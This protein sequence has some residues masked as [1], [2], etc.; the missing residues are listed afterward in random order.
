M[1]LVHCTCC[2]VPSEVLKRFSQDRALSEQQREHFANTIKIDAEMR[3]LRTQATKL[4][5][6]ASLIAA[7][8]LVGAV[9][10]A[11][12]I[13]VLR[14]Q[15][16]ARRCRARRLPTPALRPTP[17]PSACSPTTTRGGTFYSQVF[18]RNSVDGAGM[19]LISSIHYGVNYNNAFWNGSQMTYGDGD[20]SIFVDFS[21]EQR[22]DRSRVDP[23]RHPAQ[24]AA[25]L[26]QRGGRPQ[27]E[28][29][30]LLRLDVPPMGGQADRRR[31]P[32][33]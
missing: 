4:T 1:T 25:Q 14:L 31:R 20:G 32:T 8:G 26:H 30:R 10:P 22:R 7:P 19:T 27:R 5:R 15:A 6:V 33:G 28:P 3:R 17:P 11:P 29:V 21:K 16:S 9:A 12:A 2:I 18:G 24:P 13:T 23:R